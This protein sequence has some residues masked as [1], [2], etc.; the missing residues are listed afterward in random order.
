V[1]CI[2]RCGMVYCIY[3]TLCYISCYKRRSMM[4]LNMRIT[5]QHHNALYTANVFYKILTFSLW[6]FFLIF[7]LTHP[8]QVYAWDA[9]CTWFGCAAWQDDDTTEFNVL[10]GWEWDVDIWLEDIIQQWINTFLSVMW[11]IALVVLIRWWLK[12]LTA[13]GNEERYN[14]WF[15]YLKNAFIW[16]FIIGLSWFIVSLIFWAVWLVAA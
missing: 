15:K 12:M 4:S 11:L 8:M 1:T 13:G 14:S 9:W 10:D 16:L 6:A 7:G 2:Y 3:D 5:S